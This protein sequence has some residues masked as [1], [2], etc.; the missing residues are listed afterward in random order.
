MEI[1]YPI[2]KTRFVEITK[3]LT[4]QELAD[5]S[6]I[7]K[8][9]IS[10]YLHGKNSPSNF[11]AKQIADSLNDG[12]NPAWLMGLDVPRWNSGTLLTVDV[13]EKAMCDMDIVQLK[14]LSAFCDYLIAKK[15]DNQSN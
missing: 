1:K 8:S 15:T 7:S 9:S 12:T 3:D 13:I 4:A 5:K 14:R 6:N 2:V 11:T 10:Q